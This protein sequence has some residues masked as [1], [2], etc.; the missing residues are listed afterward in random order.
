M[1]LD[2][3]DRQVPDTDAACE[4]LGRAPGKD[5]SAPS[6]AMPCAL[7]RISKEEGT[8]NHNKLVVMSAPGDASESTG[9]QRFSGSG[10]R[11]ERHRRHS[12]KS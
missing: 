12:G 3:G 4:R 10:N 1:V 5:T 8:V 7:A 11:V 6:F 2:S 9:N